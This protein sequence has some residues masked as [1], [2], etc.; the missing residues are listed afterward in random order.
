[1]HEKHSTHGARAETDQSA[2]F[3]LLRHGETEWNCEKRLQGHGD[4]PLTEAGKER[5]LRWA[6][7]LAAEEWHHIIASDLGRVRETVAI[8]NEVLTLPLDFDPRLREQSWGEWE[9]LRVSDVQRRF[10]LELD[11]QIR[12]GW[13]FRPPGGE[14]RLEVKNRVFSALEDVFAR[15]RQKR[16]LVVCHLGV[17]KCLVFSAVGRKF[18]PEEPSLLNN[19]GLHTLARDRY[20]YRLVDLNICPAP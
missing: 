20:G 13:D 19:D 17:I 18:L 1:M 4:S 3:G 10:P 8:L 14:S 12:A 16:I 6:R 2:I 5:T 9:G 11:Q 15:S 7:H